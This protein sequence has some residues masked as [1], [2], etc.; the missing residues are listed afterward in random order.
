MKMIVEGTPEKLAVITNRFRSLGVKFS[1]VVDTPVFT[2]YELPET[3]LET[4][5]PIKK[6]GRKKTGRKR[7]NK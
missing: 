2:S 5:D 4:K 1:A 3:E 6:T 7:L